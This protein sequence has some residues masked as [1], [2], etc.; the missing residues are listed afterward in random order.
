VPT[1]QG[2]FDSQHEHADTVAALDR[3]DSL[4]RGTRFEAYREA[5]RAFLAA[6]R[7]FAELDPSE[8]AL[9]RHAAGETMEAVDIDRALSTAPEIPNWRREWTRILGGSLTARAARHYIELAGSAAQA[10]EIA[11][12]RNLRHLI[13]TG[14]DDL[15]TNDP[16]VGPEQ[17]SAEEGPRNAAFELWLA[18]LFRRAGLA[19]R[20]EEPDWILDTAAGAIAIAAKR[21]Q[22]DRAV[23]ARLEE[24]ARQVE[25][26]VAGGA[27]AAGMVAIEMSLVF[28]LHRK[29]WVIQEESESRELHSAIVEAMRTHHQRIVVALSGQPSVFGVLLQAKA[30]V[31][32]RE[33]Q[34][35]LTVRPVLLA[36]VGGNDT[37]HTWLRDFSAAFSN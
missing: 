4:I 7:P 32:A 5:L 31:F 19:P 12:S 16:R 14:I 17:Q 26:Q 36:T 21:V 10:A 35:F 20:K 11:E 8:R 1:F 29:H 18:V 28:D 2:Q 6:G 27:A 24:G 15:Q 23:L 34:R 30:L 33:T 25:R 3:L 22:S 37:M 9:L 13:A